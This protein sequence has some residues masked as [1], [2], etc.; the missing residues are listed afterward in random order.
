[1]RRAA[2]LIA[3]FF[4]A[5]YADAQSCP[6]SGTVLNAASCSQADVAACASALSSS[7]TV[8]NI[9]ACTGGTHWTSPVTFTIPS[10]NTNLSILGA[11]SLTTTGGGDQTV[12]VDDYNSN[13]SLLII[14]TNSTTT[15]KVR[16]AGITIKGG[17]GLI[18]YNGVVQIAG[19]SQ[20]FRWDHT[21]F[22][23]QSYSP[24]VDI[25]VMRFGDCVWGVVDHN[26][27]DMHSVGNGVQ[28]WEP[29]CYGDTGGNGDQA[30]AHNPDLGS[31]EYEIGRAHV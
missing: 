9:P 31:A 15:A 25:S 21:H 28:V 24:Q 13:N 6:A 29:G 12:I 14:T 1:M 23:M 17:S 26:I 27:F 3:V 18:H 4:V 7:T 19:F 10:G 2:L 5:L 30:W 22:N 11:G 8:V 16:L 20:N